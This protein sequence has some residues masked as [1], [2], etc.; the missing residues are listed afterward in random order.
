MDTALLIK[1][2]AG[3]FAIMNPFVALPMFLTLTAGYDA[4]R[5][6][7]TAVRV[8]LFSAVMTAV[9]LVSGSAVLHFFGIDVDDFRVAGGIV[10]LMI[11]LGMLNG[12]SS[13]HSGSKDEQKHQSDQAARA[14][15]RSTPSPSP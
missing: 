14:M 11:A 8:V 12:G 5:Q 10:L 6:R 1:A 3:L 7:R 4:S 15:W 2:F 9:I 13:V